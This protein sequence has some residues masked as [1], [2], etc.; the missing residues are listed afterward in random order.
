MVTKPTSS[1]ANNVDPHQL[2]LTI[3]KRDV[4]AAN[5]NVSKI[6]RAAQDFAQ[7]E[8]KLGT[9]DAVIDAY[10]TLIK[11]LP[12]KEMQTIDALIELQKG[13]VSH[14]Q[15]L[16]TEQARMLMNMKASPEHMK[17]EI[18]S[19][20]TALSTICRLCG[21]TGFADEI[22]RRVED[23]MKTLHVDLNPSGIT[24]G[25]TQFF[26]KMRPAV[27]RAMGEA[28]SSL[29]TGARLGGASDHL[30]VITD[31]SVATTAAPI[32]ATPAKDGATWDK[33]RQTLIG[34]GLN[35]KDAD[36]VLKPFDAAKGLDGDP[37]RVDQPMEVGVV[38][39][40]KEVQG[41]SVKQRAIVDRALQEYIPQ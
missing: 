14:I 24:D 15:Q 11:A 10:T 37:D 6:D 25:S 4:E 36:K 20:A 31:V 28:G 35:E 29:D 33:F 32:A 3:F 17:A 39:G 7:R 22:D 13:S 27:G 21:A 40:S 5:G 34:M 26:E 19:M 9:K 12:G 18:S 23:V 16:Q 2:A 1:G 30:P 41:L 8:R 38:K